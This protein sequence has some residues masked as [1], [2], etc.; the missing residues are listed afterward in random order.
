MRSMTSA[1]TFTAPGPHRDE[2][3]ARRAGRRSRHHVVQVDASLVD[4][5]AVER[6]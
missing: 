5:L 6:A 1:S 3:C 2:I 4:V